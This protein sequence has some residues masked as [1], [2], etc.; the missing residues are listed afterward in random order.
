MNGMMMVLDLLK[1]VAAF[2]L[3]VYTVRM[4]GSVKRGTTAWV[5]FAMMGAFLVFARIY[6][7]I[8]LIAPIMAETAPVWEIMFRLSEGLSNLFAMLCGM[9]GVKEL[10]DVMVRSR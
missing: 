4:A 8:G 5:F 10:Y 9:M 1:T 3:F 7:W 6:D 2:I